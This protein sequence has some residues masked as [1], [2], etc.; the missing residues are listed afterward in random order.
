MGQ[1]DMELITGQ[2]LTLGLQVKAKVELHENL[3]KLVGNY[4]PVVVV[5]RFP[6]KVARTI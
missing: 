3:V 6:L 4:T 2:D 5:E 1:T